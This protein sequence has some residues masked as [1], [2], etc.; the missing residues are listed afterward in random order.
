MAAVRAA[1]WAFSASS[2]FFWAFRGLLGASASSAA[3]WALGQVLHHLG[4]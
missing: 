1:S 4:L 3:F 2:T